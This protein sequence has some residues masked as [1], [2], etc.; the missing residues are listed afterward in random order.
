MKVKFLAWQGSF[1]ISSEMVSI[2]ANKWTFEAD[3]KTYDWSIQYESYFDEE[4]D[5]KSDGLRVSDNLSGEL[6]HDSRSVG[7]G[8]PDAQEIVLPDFESS[9]WSVDAVHGLDFIEKVNDYFRNGDTGWELF[10]FP[11]A[12]YGEERV[13][14]VG[15]FEIK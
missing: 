1:D 12:G 3:G 11:E 2:R 5:G 7:W 15:E 14:S 13:L 4:G 10:Y 9:S 6:L 8:N